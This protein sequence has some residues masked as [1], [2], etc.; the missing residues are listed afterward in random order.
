MC[1]EVRP[2]SIWQNIFH[3][4]KE[5]L[6]MSQKVQPRGKGIFKEYLMMWHGIFY[7]DS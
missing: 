2:L 3:V 1:F 7:K 4:S 5:S 6:T